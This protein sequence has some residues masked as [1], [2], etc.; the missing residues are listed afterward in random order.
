[1]A[2]CI[3][4]RGAIVMRNITCASIFF[5]VLALGLVAPASVQAQTPPYLDVNGWTVFTASADT[6][7]IY[8]SSSSG[9]DANN[10]LSQSAPVKTIAKGISLLRFGYPDWLLLKKGDTWIDETIGYLSVSGRSAA[11]P[12]LFS[13]YGIGPRPMIK[14]NPKLTEV[15]IGSLSGPG[16]GGDFLAVVGIE[17][18]AYTRDPNS[19]NFDLSTVGNQHG[20]MHFLSPIAWMLIEDC[21]FS[22]YQGQGVQGAFSKDMNV[23]IRRNVITDSYNIASV[24]HSAGLYVYNVDNLL[25][26][27]NVFDRNGWNPSVPGAQ[28]TM[29]NHNIYL[30]DVNGP[31][32][33]K[34]NISANASSHG[35]QVRPGG[36]VSD[37]LF[38]HN[39]IG[40]LIS[41]NEAPAPIAS[42][43]VTNNVITEGSDITSVLPRGFGI[44]VYWTAAGGV[45]ITNNIIAHEMSTQGNGHGVQLATYTNG[46]AT[47]VSVTNNIIYSWEAPILDQGFSNSTWPNWINAVGYVDPNRSVGSYNAAVGGQGTLADF[48]ARARLQRK[49]NWNPQLMATAVNSYIRSGFAIHSS[50]SDT[51]PPSVPTGLVGTAVSSG[52]VNLSWNPST[53]DVGVAGYNVFRNGTKIGTTL[54]TSYQDI[55][56]PGGTVSYSVSAF[57]AAGNTSAQSSR[58][59]VSYISET[60]DTTSVTPPVVA[61]GSPSNGTAIK[62]N[63]NVTI[64]A[65]ASDASGIGSISLSMDGNT[66]AMCANAT[67]CS[68]TVQ[69]KKITQGIHTIGAAAINKVGLRGEAS[70]TIVTTR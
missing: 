69:G 11:E 23:S 48:L 59:D 43:T 3:A 6:R 15:G 34:G 17:F 22:F 2:I 14:T 51:T 32:V 28:P 16:R 56:Y 8:V 39:P 26:E 47:G 37:N 42:A 35:A 1:M 44:D 45:V 55:G 66:L 29:F 19:P 49:D 64:T 63:G 12:M 50:T 18:Y 10:G 25:L 33:V 62:G 41:S 52:Q 9:S 27:E 38:V 30:H 58:V 70:I 20:G 5:A 60:G 46:S 13:A 21:K 61:I 36:T 65:S 24:G 53:D 40:L 54:G 7:L 68:A 4:S 57:D 31:A 67:S